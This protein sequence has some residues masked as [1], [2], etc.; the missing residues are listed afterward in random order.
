MI[1]R[2]NYLRAEAQ[3]NRHIRLQQYNAIMGPSPRVKQAQ[4][5][6]LVRRRRVDENAAASAKLPKAKFE[7]TGPR[8]MGPRV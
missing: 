3:F 5:A 2:S 4:R 6:Q 8:F 7:T 1:G